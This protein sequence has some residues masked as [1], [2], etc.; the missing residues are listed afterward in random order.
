MNRQ[1]LENYIFTSPLS[2]DEM[3]TEKTIQS[4]PNQ[5]ISLIE[6]SQVNYGYTEKNSGFLI[7][8]VLQHIGLCNYYKPKRKQYSKVSTVNNFNIG[9]QNNECNTWNNILRQDQVLLIQEKSH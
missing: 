4:L 2:K 6:Y 9:F 3:H 7:K 8:D 5:M 1:F